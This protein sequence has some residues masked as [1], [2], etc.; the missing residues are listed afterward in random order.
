MV[1]FPFTLCVCPD[2]TTA[3]GE[4]RVFEFQMLSRRQTMGQFVDHHTMCDT[5]AHA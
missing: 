1:M 5:L 4:L 2:I 3:I